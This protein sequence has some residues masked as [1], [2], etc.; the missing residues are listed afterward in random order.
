[1][2]R[3]STRV[4]RLPGLVETGHPHTLALTS[5]VIARL[6]RERAAPFALGR[7]R[8]AYAD[9][10]SLSSSAIVALATP[11]V[12]VVAAEPV[13]IYTAGAAGKLANVQYSDSPVVD[14]GELASTR[15]YVVDD[16]KRRTLPSIHPSPC[17]RRPPFVPKLE[18]CGDVGTRRSRA[19]AGEEDGEKSVD[20]IGAKTATS[21]VV[22]RLFVLLEMRPAN[23]LFLLDR[24]ILSRGRDRTAETCKLPVL[25][26]DFCAC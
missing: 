10:S 21:L 1:M 8:R 5:A 15:T 25:T 2:I 12:V 3:S 20:D 13:V 26:F 9:G 11:V 24:I 6:M 18:T 17:G 23:N 14:R 22:M 19:R 4:V 7:L 16:R